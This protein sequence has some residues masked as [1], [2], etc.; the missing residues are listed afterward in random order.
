V[1][2]HRPEL[3]NLLANHQ[4][5]ALGSQG[6]LFGPVVVHALNCGL[7]LAGHILADAHPHCFWA[8]GMRRFQ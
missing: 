8:V 3:L 6:D 4:S 1:T 7:E 2:H 5:E